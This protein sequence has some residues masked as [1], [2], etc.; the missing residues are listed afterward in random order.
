MG[1]PI[2]QAPG[3]VSG[4]PFHNP[5]RYVAIDAKDIKA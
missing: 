5:P 1:P 3:P 4:G 2:P